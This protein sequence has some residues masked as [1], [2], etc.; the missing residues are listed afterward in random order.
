MA[1]KVHLLNAV[2]WNGRD[3]A[4]DAK[5]RVYCHVGNGEWC[6]T[7]SETALLG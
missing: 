6:S 7:T 4:V 3:I 1:I 5:G 2:D